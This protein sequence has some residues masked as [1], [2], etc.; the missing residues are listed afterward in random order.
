[1]IDAGQRR[2]ILDRAY[3]SEHSPELMT[4]ISGGEAHLFHGFI[5]YAGDGW[6]I[7][8]GYSLEDPSCSD[9]LEEIVELACAR[10]QPRYCWVMAPRLPAVFEA[11]ARERETDEYY[12]LDLA[13]FDPPRRLMREVERAAERLVVE[14]GREMGPD[15][16]SLAGEFIGLAVPHERVQALYRAMP[17]FVRRSPD[18]LVLNAR[19]PEGR[20]AAYYVMDMAPANFASYIVGCHSRT[21]RAPH[22]SD[23]LFLEMI[24]AAR[25]AG[26]RCIDLGLGVHD[27]IRR[28]K[29]KWGA[30]VFMPYEMCEIQVP[31]KAR[32][33]RSLSTGRGPVEKR[34][35]FLSIIGSFTLPGRRGSEYKMLWEIRK[36]DAHNLLGGTAHFFCRS[37]RRS[38]ERILA[39]VDRVLFEGP[40]G[41]ES[42]RLVRERGAAPPGPSPLFA[43]LDRATRAKIAREFAPRALAPALESG[44][45]P[46][47]RFSVEDEICRG[48][49]DGRTPWLAFFGMW[50]EFLR[51]RGW[52]YSV[53]L[54]AHQAAE[55][56][57]KPIVYMESIDEQVRAMEGIP[58]EA[59]VTFLGMIGRWEALSREH[60][61]R[62]IAGDIERIFKAIGYFPSRC[63]SIIDCRDPVFFERMTPYIE[64][65]GAA[66]LVGASHIP[67]LVRRLEE[68]GWSVR[69]VGR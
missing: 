3:V 67:G 61:R 30:V 10:F 44:F 63:E 41:E 24:A 59:I 26:K 65:G 40:L 60:A 35:K 55:R 37:Y 50:T 46:A 51:K 31:G 23:L 7:V 34:A 69:P 45:A 19:N 48:L 56:L 9:R 42:M 57:G 62:F 4:I 18:A 8:N 33:L 38:F 28:F 15:H 1:M 22:A 6:V 43:A 5:V 17:G 36:G 39:G 13:A 66:V 2:Y 29:T 11:L 53:D 20:L 32:F 68:A 52:V 58:F 49:M 64:K 12:R 54:E 25:G 16:A 21:V 27:G 14:R 47:L